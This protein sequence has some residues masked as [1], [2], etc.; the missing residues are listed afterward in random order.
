MIKR[1]QIFLGPRRFRVFLALLGSTG[2]ASLALTV[3]A[4][5]SP[6]ATGIQSLLLVTFILGSSVLV[7]G[8]LPIEE[9]LRWLAIIVPSALAIIIGSLALPHLTGLF[10]GAGLGWIVAGIFIFRGRTR[11]T[12]LPSGGQGDAQ[13]RLPFRHREHVDGDWGEAESGAAFSISRRVASIGRR[14]RIG[15]GGLSTHDGTRRAIGGGLQ[16]LG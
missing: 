15:A 1:V 12:E 6:I 10:V 5:G 3:L 8:R 2:L 16:R 7:L 9:R 14:S 13:G 4:Q 11:S